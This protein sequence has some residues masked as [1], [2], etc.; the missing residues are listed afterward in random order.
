MAKTQ[1]LYFVDTHSTGEMIAVVE[2]A[3]NAVTQDGYT[4]E[5]K[6][7]S[8]A[9]GIK[10][11]GIFTDTD[12]SMNAMGGTYS[13]IPSRFHEHIVSKA[14]A[15]GYKDPRHMEIQNAQYFDAE[16][17]KGIKKAKKFARGNYSKVGSV[18]PRDF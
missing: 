2:K 11:R 8:S 6:T 16:Y 1:R 7:V 4:D 9:K 17:E 15:V 12:L 10:I 18:V 13:N 3:K 14:I 5:Y